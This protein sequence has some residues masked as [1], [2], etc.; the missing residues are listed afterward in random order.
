MKSLANFVPNPNNYY[1]LDYSWHYYQDGITGCN[2]S[3][4]IWTNQ[5]EGFASK[6]EA[7]EV[8]KEKRKADRVAMKHYKELN[9]PHSAKGTQGGTRKIVHGSRFK[10][11]FKKFRDE[12]YIDAPSYFFKINA[13]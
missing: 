2:R 5:G 9:C 10:N 12:L 7:N 11:A 6:R 4:I 8:I 13:N 1:I 3:F